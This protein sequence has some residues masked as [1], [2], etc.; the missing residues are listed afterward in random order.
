MRV[1]MRVAAL[2]PLQRQPGAQPG[3]VDIH[4]PLLDLEPADPARESSLRS[5][6]V[7]GEAL[8]H[9]E[10]ARERR[11][12]AASGVRYAMPSLA[13]H[14]PIRRASSPISRARMTAPSGSY[15]VLAERAG[16]DVLGVRCGGQ[17]GAS[18]GAEH[19]RRAT[20]AR[21]RDRAEPDTS[22]TTS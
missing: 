6:L 8:E 16:L 19:E 17:L 3:R 15:E 13:M 10:A 2:A 11:L 7:E 4:A 22:S 9:A 20:D 5:A 1:T 21:P 12:T 14:A 18:V